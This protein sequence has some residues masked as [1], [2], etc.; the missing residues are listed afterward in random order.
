M[1]VLLLAIFITC[2]P[3]DAAHALGYVTEI[4]PENA[5]SHG[6]SLKVD[7]Q[8]IDGVLVTLTMCRPNH[9]RPESVSLLVWEKPLSERDPTQNLLITASVGLQM[10]CPLK[11]VR[12]GDSRC[13]EVR[14][15]RDLLSRSALWFSKRLSE[16]GIDM[17]EVQLEAFAKTTQ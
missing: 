8:L 11:G 3:W 5:S 13:F 10:S 14:V 1:R 7:P 16:P 2:V 9:R 17:Y 15:R 4:T 6:I 12:R